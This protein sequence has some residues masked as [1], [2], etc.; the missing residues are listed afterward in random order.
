MLA[1]PTPGEY[2]EIRWL[3]DVMNYES[4][5]SYDQDYDPQRGEYTY[6]P[7]LDVLEDK[8]EDDH[9]PMLVEALKATGFTKC[10]RVHTDKLRVTDGHHRIAAALDLGWQFVPVERINY[11]DDDSGDWHCDDD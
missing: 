4:V 8:R 9:Y 6:G 10:V 2:V 3:A 11:C 7:V 5:D 1:D